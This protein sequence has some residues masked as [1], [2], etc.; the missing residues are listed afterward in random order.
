[1]SCKKDEGTTHHNACDCREEYISKLEGIAIAAED[2]YRFPSSHNRTHL[3]KQ[4]ES[5]RLQVS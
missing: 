2:Y 1:M 5:L 3:K 4:L